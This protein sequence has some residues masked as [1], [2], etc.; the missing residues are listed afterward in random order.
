MSL[1]LSGGASCPPHVC[2]G[3]LQVLRLLQSIKVNLWDLWTEVD[4]S[5]CVGR[6]L[7]STRP[8][9]S[10]LQLGPAP[11]HYQCGIFNYY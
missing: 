5:L 3:S 1:V 10:C 6:V 9:D 2:A 11:A 8:D 7:P 4:P